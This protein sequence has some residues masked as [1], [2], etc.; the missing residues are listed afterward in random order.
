MTRATSGLV[1]ATFLG[2]CQPAAAQYQDWEQAEQALPPA[3]P[4]PA[5]EEARPGMA[6]AQPVR[7]LPVRPREAPEEADEADAEVEPPPEEVPNRLLISVQTSFYYNTYNPTGLFETSVFGFAPLMTASWRFDR[8]LRIGVTGGLGL[9]AYEGFLDTTGVSIDGGRDVAAGNPHAWVE[10]LGST[11]A[12]AWRAGGGLSI[13]L[14]SSCP[15]MRPCASHVA[16]GMHGAWDLWLWAPERLGT[17]GSG[18][19]RRRL[20]QGRMELTVAGDFAIL[21]DVSGRERDSVGVLQVLGGLA[22]QP[23]SAF[24]VGGDVLV[25]LS[26][27]MPARDDNSQISVRPYGK[28]ILSRGDIVFGLMLPF[29]APFGFGFSSGGVYGLFVRADARLL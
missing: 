4:R 22:Y 25:V 18:E 1:V 7:D 21:F 28:L 3:P 23:S 14:S 27:D 15:A 10:W 17:I 16:A 29:D 26:G 2:L 8:P 9:A 11:T 13:P 19:L 5:G 12:W 24:A 20:A 6:P